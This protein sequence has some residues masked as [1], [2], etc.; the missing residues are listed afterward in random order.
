MSGLEFEL[1]FPDDFDDEEWLISAKGY[2]S[3]LVVAA[4]AR[5]F[6]LNFF[7]PVRLNQ[8]AQSAV[9]ELPC[10]V[11]RNL[12]IVSKVDRKHITAAV[13]WLAKRGFEDFVP[14]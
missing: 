8:E 14:E 12:V 5:R 10:L 1:M 9:E 7:D 2:V 3:D 13:S 11:E 6:R 4:G